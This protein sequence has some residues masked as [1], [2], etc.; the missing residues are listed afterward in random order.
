MIEMSSTLPD[1]DNLN[2]SELQLPAYVFV[3]PNGVFINL[4]PPPA[5]D[6]LQLFID[7]LFSNES[8]FA[9]LDY[10]RFLHLLY[11]DASKP[12]SGSATKVRVASSIM[13]FPPERMELYKGIK[14]M[15][16]GERAEYMFEPAFIETV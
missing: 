10:A 14:I 1:K 7:R 4:S 6:I 2:P 5:Q 11:G 13:R 3:R 15:D 9:G 8:R 12:L 16:N